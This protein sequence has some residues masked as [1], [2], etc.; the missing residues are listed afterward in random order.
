MKPE[1][2]RILLIE[3]NPG[4]V[5]LLKEH[6][7]GAAML[8]ITKSVF[9]W[10]TTDRLGHA[11]KLI[12]TNRFDVALLDLSLPDSHGLDT[13]VRLQQFV[14]NLPIIVL[15]GLDD[16]GV[17]IDAVR[18]GAQDYLVKGDVSASLLMRSI[19]YAIERKRLN[20]L[21]TE[22][23]DVSRIESRRIQLRRTGVRMQDWVEKICEGYQSQAREKGIQLSHTI[24]ATMEPVCLDSDKIGRIFDKFIGNSLRFTQSG[25][26]ISVEV[27]DGA[28][29]IECI[30]S[31]TGTGIAE[32]D[33]SKLFIKSEPLGSMELPDCPGA[34]YSLSLCREW[35]EKHGGK[36][37]VQSEPG[38]RTTF[39]FTLAKAPFPAIL[40]VESVKKEIEIIKELLA[41]DCYI[42]LDAS[43]G[44]S[45]FIEA[46]EKQPSLIVLD[47][48]M[49]DMSG[50]EFIGRL[51]QD[52]R[53]H[54]IPLL[55]VRLMNADKDLQFDS[56]V[57][58]V[59]PVI[60]M[61]LKQS[62]LR[63]KIHELLVE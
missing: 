34:V 3:D 38:K 62:T 47:M 25:G 44:K 18:N 58:S 32:E 49:N 48:K 41:K 57:H 63:E 59:F 17:A 30:V 27:R 56:D 1:T 11:L 39:R 6:L 2:L 8:G 24:S 15:S 12:E 21:V 7:S 33:L 60:T 26:A 45:G 36:I 10:S 46:V 14:P 13:F 22:A 28:G 16:S 52:S 40:V 61:P 55:A 20:R 51:K 29:F 19:H 35:I 50:Y 31:D 5:R 23:T 53:T 37:T 9:E 43:D 54:S 42:I 4:D